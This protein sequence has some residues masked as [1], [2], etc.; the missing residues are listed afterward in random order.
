MSKPKLRI[1]VGVNDRTLPLLAGLVVIEGVKSE[2]ITAPPEEIFARAF[3]EQAFDVTELS[4]SNYL[5]LAA[6]GQ[7]PYIGLPIFPSRS[8]RHSAIYIRTDRGITGPRDLVGRTV[9][10]RE[11]SMTAALV[12]R[13]VLEDEYGLRAQ[14]IKWRYGR[15]DSKDT[16]P[17][18]RMLPNGVELEQI[19]ANDTLSDLLGDGHLDAMIAYKPP[20]VFLDGHPAVSRLFEEY[21]SIEADYAR[22]TGIMP[23]MHL[24]GI[25]RELALEHPELM[26]K[27]CEGF[28]AARKFSLDRLGESQALYTMLPWG[29]KEADSAKA[30]LGPGFWAYGVGPNLPAIEA[31]CRYSHVQGISPRHLRAE[32]LFAAQSIDWVP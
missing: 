24:I 14:D 9:G 15:A 31:L 3:D 10:V 32:E 20:P 28:E 25:R 7:S 22:R 13:G 26:V 4:F 2:F 30:L 1:A 16:H 18:A 21:A 12:A 19:D 8:F 29:A 17:I 5:Y 27:V 23:I 11:Y 6:T